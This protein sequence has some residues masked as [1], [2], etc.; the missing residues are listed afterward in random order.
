MSFK[1]TVSW[2]LG[3]LSL[4]LLIAFI[5]LAI[6]IGSFST[7]PMK[8]MS[9]M[10]AGNDLLL[11]TT[12]REVPNLEN[13]TVTVW[14][15]SP[16]EFNGVYQ[17]VKFAKRNDTHFIRYDQFFVVK[18]NMSLPPYQSGGQLG[19]YEGR[20]VEEEQT[21][22][23]N[24]EK[25]KSISIAIWV[26]F[27]LFFLSL[28][29]WVVSTIDIPSAPSKFQDPVD[30]RNSSPSKFQVPVASGSIQSGECKSR[31]IQSFSIDST[32]SDTKVR[33]RTSKFSLENS[34]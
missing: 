24:S 13:K 25:A 6:Y 29:V 9:I 19:F 31:G 10:E 33:P 26:L 15:V 16:P 2:I 5:V 32:L 14:D 1:R 18:P 12:E 7:P 23:K 27:G 8:I 11:I 20:S 28:I 21:Y 4:L 22:D 34:R 3:I 30:D 17:F